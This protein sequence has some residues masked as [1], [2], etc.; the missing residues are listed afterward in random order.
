MTESETIRQR[1]YSAE[2]AAEHLW[3]LYEFYDIE[4]EDDSKVLL[5]GEDA[6]KELIKSERLLIKA[7]MKGTLEIK[8]I[9]DGAVVPV[10]HLKRSNHITGP[11][12]YHEI[13]GQVGMTNAKN[14]I[15]Y[16]DIEGRQLSTV[17][18]MCK[19]DLADIV[20]LKGID[21]RIA[22]RLG[23]LFLGA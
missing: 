17:A 16:N 13:T 23:M 14:S 15:Q 8:T 18:G 7:I 20:A 1:E 5:D 11:L 2:T 3:K 21:I 19:E 6:Q 10:Q 22:K 9:E 12:V 4:V